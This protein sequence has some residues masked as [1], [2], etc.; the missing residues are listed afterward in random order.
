MKVSK[1]VAYYMN[2]AYNNYIIQPINDESGSY[3]YAHILELDGCQSTGN[4]FEEA[5]ENL[6]GAMRGL[7]ETKLDAGFD[8]PIPKETNNYSGK[9]VVRI[10]KTLHYKLAMEAEK[11]GI[12]LNQYALYKLSR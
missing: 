2:L 5:Y 9:F 11:E 3:Y 1:D 10:P 6:R 7:I 12:S 4:T 8:I